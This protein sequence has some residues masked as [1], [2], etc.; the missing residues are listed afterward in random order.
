M[1]GGT[2]DVD[3]V[4][5]E[6]VVVTFRESD[7]KLVGIGG[8]GG[9]VDDEVE[10]AQVVG[11]GEARFAE[12]LFEADEPAIADAAHLGALA[13]VVE[14]L[15]LR[16]LAIEAPALIEVADVVDGLVCGEI[17]GGAVAVDYS[18]ETVEGEDC[19]A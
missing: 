19:D 10:G 4:V 17:F 1:A 5:V 2:G 14:E 15:P 3:D 11:I 16:G 7:G 6:G 13:G 9:G 18:C 8:G 12:G